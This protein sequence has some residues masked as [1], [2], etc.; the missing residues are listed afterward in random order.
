MSF[1]LTKTDLKKSALCPP[2]LAP[3]TLVAVEE[4]YLKPNGVTVQKCD[5]ETD[6]GYIVPVWFNDKVPTN[7]IEYV[8][9]ADKITFDLE[10]MSDF[11]FNPKEYIGKT[12][13]GNISH[14]KT[15]DGKVVAQIDNFYETGKV[16]F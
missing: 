15:D 12:C 1:T 3:I 10:N 4:S 16:P 8:Q 14:R 5:F 11:S 6:K 9:A 7:M 2:G 13:V